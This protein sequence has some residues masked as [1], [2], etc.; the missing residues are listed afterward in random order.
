MKRIN[1]FLG[2]VLI[3]LTATLVACPATTPALT[4]EQGTAL[5]GQVDSAEKVLA[6]ALLKAQFKLDADKLAAATQPAMASVVKADEKSVAEIKA[7]HDADVKYGPVAA[8][9]AAAATQPVGTNTT[10]DVYHAVS[11]LIPEPWRTLGELALGLV[12]LATVAIQQ[13]KTNASNV[14]NQSQ[15]AAIKSAVEQELLVV[16]PGAT[17]VVYDITTEHPAIDAL[18][19]T[20][21]NAGGGPV[22]QP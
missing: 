8:G 18:L 2:L 13:R 20:I 4:P 6:D 3:F 10:T 17:K 5:V 16:K 1:I 11:P 14:A 7:A 12:G 15:A 19:T 21:S 9:L 22:P